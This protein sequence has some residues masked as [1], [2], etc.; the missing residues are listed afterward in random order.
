M[1]NKDKK[2]VANVLNKCLGY[3]K[4]ELVLIITDDKLQ[5]MGELFY[6]GALSLGIETILLKM[7]SRFIHGEE[8]PRLIAEALKKTDIALLVTEKSL[9]HTQARLVA[10]RKFGVRIASLPGIDRKIFARSLLIDY[11]KLKKQSQKLAAILTKG[12]SV[13]VETDKGTKVNF[14]IAGRRGLTDDG[15]YTKRG[16]FGNLPAGEACI[17]P[18]EGTTKGKLIVDASFA[19]FGKIKKPIEIEIKKGKAEKISFAPLRNLLKPFGRKALNIAEFGLG[20]NPKAKVT[21]NVLED[22]KC[23]NT[24]HI[25][26]GNN[27]FFGGKVDAPCHLDGVFYNPRVFVDGKRIL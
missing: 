27:R 7:K 15:L 9:S 8:P 26:L 24:A 14:S 22:E 5:E 11:N 21:G 3:K 16:A 19:G 2:I 23:L 12:K 13:R 20:L 17:G 6:Q 25:A 1:K 18:I 10:S 4:G